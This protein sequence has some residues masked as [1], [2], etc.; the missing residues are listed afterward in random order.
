MIFFLVFEGFNV[1]NLEN[2]GDG[3]MMF[4]SENGDE[5]LMSECDYLS[6]EYEI[7]CM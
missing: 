3:L 1:W 2:D 6:I 5:S 4:C 7:N